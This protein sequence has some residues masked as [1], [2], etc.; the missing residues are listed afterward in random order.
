MRLLLLAIALGLVVVAP[1]QAQRY[2]RGGSSRYDNCCPSRARYLMGYPRPYPGPYARV[3]GYRT[4]QPIMYPMPYP[5]AYPTEPSYGDPPDILP[6]VD[7]LEAAA[8]SY[9]LTPQS[10]TSQP[11]LHAELS[12]PAAEA[13]LEWPVG[14]RVV[15]PEPTEPLRQQIESSLTVLRQQKAAGGT[16]DAHLAAAAM[17]ALDRL[18]ELVLRDKQEARLPL[19][20]SEE[21]ERFV[22]KLRG[23]LRKLQQ[24]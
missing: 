8:F 11:A 24:G 17:Q 1:A 3:P 9:G 4:S 15:A 14:L 2:A 12:A 7:A 20:V 18:W 23:A 13:A 19:A 10:D 16:L 6:S 5:V 21:A 22:A